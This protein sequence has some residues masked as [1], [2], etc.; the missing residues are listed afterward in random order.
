MA[1][2]AQR[3]GLAK[4]TLYLYF[5]AKEELFLAALGSELSTWLDLLAAELDAGIGTEPR[6][7]AEHLV[8]TL[9]PR[10]TLIELLPL[11]RTLLDQ[12]GA[13]QTATRF[14]RTLGE[15]LQEAA[16]VVERVL[17]L[18][19]GEGKRVLLRTLALVVGL[20]QIPDPTPSLLDGSGSSPI[21]PTDFGHELLESIAAMLLGMLAADGV[22]TAMTPRWIPSA[23]VSVD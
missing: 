3:C 6:A 20:R 1:E 4:G 23:T 17:P 13:G 11:Q 19:A 22:R 5:Q 14:S 9:M 15:K 12:S 8:R 21:Q 2:I 10:Q 18:A 7:F 16:L